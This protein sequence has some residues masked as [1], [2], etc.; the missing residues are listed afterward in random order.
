[1]LSGVCLGTND[2]AKAGSFYDAVLAEIGWVRL[3]EGAA[4]IGYGPRDGWPALFIVIPFNEKAA[5][6]GNGVQ[7]ILRAHDQDAVDRFHAVALSQG[8]TDEGA[9]GPRDYIAG[10]YGAYCRDLD[11]NKLHAQFIPT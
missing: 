9:P 10:Y 4:E 5:T 2:L 8:G 6:A 11:G 7:V 1:M 3:L